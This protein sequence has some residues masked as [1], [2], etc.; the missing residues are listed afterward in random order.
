MEF[1]GETVFFL[2]EQALSFLGVSKCW[3]F[4]EESE[5]GEKK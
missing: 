5:I 2:L 4:L 1:I 3:L